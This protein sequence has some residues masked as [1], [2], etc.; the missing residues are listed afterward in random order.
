MFGILKFTAKKGLAFRE[1]IGSQ[2]K[3]KYVC[4]GSTWKKY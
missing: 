2:F 1:P 4:F 3:K